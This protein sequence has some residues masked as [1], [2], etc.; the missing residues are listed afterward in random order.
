M[1]P[2][3]TENQFPRR[4]LAAC[5]DGPYGH[6]A[7]TATQTEEPSAPQESMPCGLWLPVNAAWEVAPWSTG[8]IAH[9]AHIQ[10]V[11]DV[12]HC[13]HHQVQLLD[14]VWKG[15][16]LTSGRVHRTAYTPTRF[17][18]SVRR[19]RHDPMEQGP[20]EPHTG[21]STFLLSSGGVG[22]GYY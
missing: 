19:L 3:P 10:K 1:G 20:T 7:G 18:T 11:P 16:M 13:A 14:A 21:R 12:H 5:L 4:T 17:A 9:I 2:I 22:G 6:M 8:L 15:T